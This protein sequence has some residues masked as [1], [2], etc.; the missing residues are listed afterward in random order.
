M[1]VKLATTNKFIQ[2]YVCYLSKIPSSIFDVRA[3]LDGLFPHRRMT[4]AKRLGIRVSIVIMADGINLSHHSLRL[5][6]RMAQRGPAQ[7]E[8]KQGGP[9]LQLL[10]ALHGVVDFFDMFSPGSGTV[11]PGIRLMHRPITT[12]T[13]AQ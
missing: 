12:I 4:Q 7:P 1:F 9:P 6:G 13:D 11:Y 3:V 8:P 5:I 10:R 2:E